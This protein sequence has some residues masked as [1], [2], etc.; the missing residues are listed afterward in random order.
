[1]NSVLLDWSERFILLDRQGNTLS[2]PDTTIPGE[3]ARQN[4]TS[5]QD[6]SCEESWQDVR[7]TLEE[8]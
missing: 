8:R 6:Q 2:T 3:E 4:G 1:M 7:E 5:E